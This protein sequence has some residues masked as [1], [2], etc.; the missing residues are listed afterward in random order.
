MTDPNAHKQ[1][2]DFGAKCTVYVRQ[3]WFQ[4]TDSKNN[5]LQASGYLT[6]L[7]GR[8]LAKPTYGEWKFVSRGI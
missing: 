5:I 2:K 8:P 4:A 7:Q 1:M 3:S 6:F